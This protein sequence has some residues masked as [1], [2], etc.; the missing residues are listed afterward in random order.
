MADFDQEVDDQ[1]DLSLEELYRRTKEVHKRTGFWME[2]LY[3]R[4]QKLEYEAANSNGCAHCK[5]Q[6]RKLDE[7]WDEAFPPKIAEE[8][9]VIREAFN[10]FIEGF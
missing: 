9:K 7:V 1:P 2:A 6:E 8:L 4:A 10:R 3:Q 5:E